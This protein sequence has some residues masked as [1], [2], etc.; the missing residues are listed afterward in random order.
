MLLN[1]PSRVSAPRGVVA[2]SRPAWMR[3]LIDS[4]SIRH[5]WNKHVLWCLH[6]FLH[7]ACMLCSTWAVTDNCELNRPRVSYEVKTRLLWEQKRLS[8]RIETQACLTAGF[9]MQKKIN[10]AHH[11]NVLVKY[12][13]EN[14]EMKNYFVISFQE[15]NLNLERDILQ[16]MKFIG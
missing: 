1:S 5:T 16:G 13:P 14:D 11:N 6:Y 15:K 12:T 8:I 2:T 7:T 10:V 9:N 4:H 3:R